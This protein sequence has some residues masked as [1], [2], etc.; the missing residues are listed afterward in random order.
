MASIETTI[1]DLP[2]EILYELFKYLNLPDLINCRLTNKRW[3]SISDIT[4]VRQLVVSDRIDEF[5][6]LCKDS[7]TFSKFRFYTKLF[8]LKQHLRKLHIRC[9]VYSSHIMFKRILDFD[10]SIFNEFIYLRELDLRLK[11]FLVNDQTSLNLHNLIRFKLELI[12]MFS[13]D[14][15][16]HLIAP[17]LEFLNCDLH[18]IDVH[19]PE[20]IKQFS[21]NC[22]C[23]DNP[24]NF[25]KVKMMKNLEVLQ[26]DDSSVDF[27]ILNDLSDL[28]KLKELR[29]SDQVTDQSS[30]QLFDLVISSFNNLKHLMKFGFNNDRDWVYIVRNYESETFDFK[31]TLHSGEFKQFNGGIFFK[32]K[33]DSNQMISFYNQLKDN[34][35]VYTQNIVQLLNTSDKPTC[36]F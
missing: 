36:S 6:E 28:P 22:D 33:I 27:S 34:G 30:E 21:T 19:H 26:F 31:Y 5:K 13:F 25:D 35:R 4:R 23:D 1:D 20:S 7:I 16:V 18:L 15:E 3:K 9:T 24:I 17:R 2:D 8:K 10:L 12:E 32:T 14:S 11:N 29:I